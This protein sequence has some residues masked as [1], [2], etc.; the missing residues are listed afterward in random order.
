MANRW[1]NFNVATGKID[2]A[3]QNGVDKYAGVKPYYKNLGPR[4]GFAYQALRTPWSAAASASSTIPTGSEGGSL[5]LFRQLPFGSTVSISPGD[6]NVGSARQ[7]W[8]PA[9][10][11]REL[12]VANNP[13]GAMFAVDPHFRPSYAEQF[14]LTVEHEIAPWACGQDRGGG[15]S[16][17]ASL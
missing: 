6:I 5:R 12:R 13:F 2:I 17:P 7:R 16:R 8:L 10:A 4:F 15:Q 14:N 9:A 1:A 11:A 3:G